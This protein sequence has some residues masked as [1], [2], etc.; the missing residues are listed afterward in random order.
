[1]PCRVIILFHPL[2]QHSLNKT[3]SLENNESPTPPKKGKLETTYNITFSTTNKRT[4]GSFDITKCPFH[5]LSSIYFFHL[6]SPKSGSSEVNIIG[7]WLKA[8]I[9]LSD[10][11]RLSTTRRNI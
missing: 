3:Q 4:F 11:Y 9:I 10:A 1:M 6:S 5:I 2:N 8:F 7:F